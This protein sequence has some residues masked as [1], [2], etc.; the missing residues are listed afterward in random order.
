MP[1]ELVT[2]VIPVWTAMD[3]I[4]TSELPDDTEIT[5][6]AE[7]DAALQRLLRATLANDVDPR[8][9]WEYHTTADDVDNLEVMIVELQS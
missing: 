2:V 4:M 3:M 1:G 6:P 5:T 7:F 9:S 8:G